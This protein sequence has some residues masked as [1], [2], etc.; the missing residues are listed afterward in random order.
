[1]QTEYAFLYPAWFLLLPF[2]WWRLWHACGILPPPFPALALRHPAAAWAQQDLRQTQN[3]I[4]RRVWAALLFTLLL[5]ALAEPVRYGAPLPEK[6]APVDLVLV[7]D[8]SVDMVLRDYVIEGERVSRLHMMKRLL[9]KFAA[10]F[11]GRRMALVVVGSP[12]ALWLPLTDERELLRHLLGRL[13]L[14]LAGGYSALGDALA[15]TAEHFGNEGERVAVL[16]STASHPLGRLSPQE[17]AQRLKQAGV[18]LYTMGVGATNY[19]AAERG[20]GG[21]IYEPVDLALLGELAKQTGGQGFHANSSEAVEQALKAIE[22]RHIR[23]L[24]KE[25]APHTRQPLYV[26]PLA[27]ALLLLAGQAWR[28]GEEKRTRDK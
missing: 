19:A 3:P 16:F 11:N 26:F 13:E 12:S 17:G 4:S 25:S 7:V 14:S 1:M 8:V 28:T 10:S 27:L 23:A 2:F 18:T 20:S 21:L 24:A 5:T 6:P 22:R 15:L 9:D